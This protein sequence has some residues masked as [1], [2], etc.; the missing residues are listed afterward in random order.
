MVRDLV[1]ALAEAAGDALVVCVPAHSPIPEGWYPSLRA[2]L[3]LRRPRR[4]AFLV[5]G[6]AW[7]WTARRYRFACLHLPAWGVPPGVPVPVVATF[8]DATP[9]LFPTGLSFWQKKRAALALASLRRATRVHAPSFFAKKQL[10][11]LYPELEARTVVIPHGVH[12]RFVPAPDPSRG[13][14]LGVGGGERHKNWELILEVYAQPEARILPPLT[15]VGAAGHEPRL[16]HLTRDLGLDER[17]TWR[18]QADE[19]SLIRLYQNAL[20]LVFPSRNEGFGLPALEAMACGCPVLAA[21]AG[22]L[23]EVC[24]EA[25]VLLPPDDPKAWLEALRGLKENPARAQDLRQRGL[26]RARHFTWNRTALRLLELYRDAAR[27]ESSA[28]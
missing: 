9:Q 11:A 13:F 5:D 7:A 2:T 26:A 21:H 6:P 14:V 4:G 24:G 15:V 18:P 19:A 8:H 16:R 23:P 1:P 27:R 25:G 3:K 28:R 20:A 17:V 12:R 22:A 10:A